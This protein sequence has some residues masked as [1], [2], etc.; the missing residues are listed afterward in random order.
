MNIS[1]IN[2]LERVQRHLTKRIIELLDLSYQERLTA[3]NLQTLEH[4]RLSCDSTMYYS[5][6]QPNALGCNDY[7]NAIIPPYNLHFLSQF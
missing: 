6:S 1:H 5:F 7:I 3:L 4:R 2:S